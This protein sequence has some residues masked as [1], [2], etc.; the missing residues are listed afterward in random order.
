MFIPVA[1]QAWLI[2]GALVITAILIHY[3]MLRL[4]SVFI[5]KWPL[6]HRFKV[7]SGLL[8]ALTAHVIEIWM[9]GIGYYFLVDAS[10]F[11]S[12]VGA[13]QHSLL[14]CV[15]FSFVMYTSLGIGDIPVLQL[16]GVDHSMSPAPAPTHV[17]TTT[18]ALS[19]TADLRAESN[20]FALP[21]QMVRRHTFGVFVSSSSA[22]G[23]ALH[24]CTEAQCM[25]ARLGKYSSMPCP[26]CRRKS[27][28]LGDLEF[29]VV[30][31]DVGRRQ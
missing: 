14:D 31:S 30:A 27:A 4:L 10:Q 1:L 26:F 21:K 23:F 5:P 2:N 17:T 12:L 15:Y 24:A 18:A 28:H 7:V 13:Y 6:Q 29:M 11:G 19:S 25:K 8:G 20:M 3:E 22:V 16:S 9:F